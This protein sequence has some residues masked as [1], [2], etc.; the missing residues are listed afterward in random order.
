M[1]PAVSLSHLCQALTSSVA[2]TL[3]ERQQATLALTEFE[4]VPGFAAT[5]F[6]LVISSGMGPMEG[7]IRQAAAIYLKNLAYKR[8]RAFEKLHDQY[9]THPI[10]FTP[11]IK[12]SFR[13]NIVQAISQAPPLIRAQ[14]GLVFQSMLDLDFPHEWPELIP[15]LLEM[16]NSQNPVY[17]GS[18]LYCLRL[19]AK[20][21]QYIMEENRGDLNTIV[22]NIFPILLKLF[23]FLATQSCLET[24]Q[25]ETLLVKIF[26][27]STYLAMPPFL[28]VHDNVFPWI[29][30]FVRILEADVPT[31]GAPEDEE[32]KAKWMPWKIKK[33][34]MST[35]DRLFLRYGNI[36]KR[37]NS[38]SN[39]FAKLFV[40]T[41]VN[42][43]LESLF[44]LL[45]KP[46]TKQWPKRII[47][48]ILSF[49]SSSIYPSISWKMVKTNLPILFERILFPLLYFTKED[50]ED[51]NDEPEEWVQD[52][53]S[54]EA[55]F[56]SPKAVVISFVFD[57]VKLRGGDPEKVDDNPLVLFMTY[58]GQA[59]QRY[60][61]AS[62]DQKNTAEKEG[63]LHLLGNIASL[64]MASPHFHQG[65]EDLIKTQVGPEMSS[66]LP[67]MRA[68][69][70]WCFSQFAK[71]NFKDT[72]FFLGLVQS[73]LMLMQDKSLPVRIFA[74]MAL[75]PF[76]KNPIVKPHLQPMV[77]QLIQAYL[78]LMQEIEVDNLVNSL[79]YLLKNYPDEANQY[80]PVILKE[81][82]T[83]FQFLLD[84]EVT[85]NDPLS[86]E[87]NA[88]QQTL[89]TI[90]TLLAGFK[91][92]NLFT[93]LDP[94]VV[95]VLLTASPNTVELLE[96]YITLCAVVTFSGPI[97]DGLW[98]FFD[99]MCDFALDW[100][101]DYM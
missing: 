44:T 21:Y 100:A 31:A 25:M 47:T 83:K 46:A 91:D 61:L 27:S 30:Q 36:K 85:L 86:N 52:Q 94:L 32:E 4:K 26:Y 3:G 6:Q 43:L 29:A 15:M 20:K 99:K 70:V 56:W 92:P 22:Q 23:Q 79:Q 71:F 57:V 24:F 93:A 63:C 8:Y 58:I 75:K 16:I 77:P 48:C 17:I 64:L 66:P 69:A 101:G 42:K 87:F 80:A 1:D 53:L 89:R 13:A 55:E 34:A 97:S 65:L 12:A 5:L 51:F 33:W 41:Y 82:A 10:V 40:N 84:Q 54:F 68:R 2:E 37:N 95:Q 72:E 88:C 18:S 67:F 96:E 62:P 90:I 7:V 74:A 28:A 76:T 49:V 50:F 59:L 9:K 14:L 38:P 11:E 35:L 19:I 45:N 98:F 73:C 60:S 39:E 78:Q 81:L